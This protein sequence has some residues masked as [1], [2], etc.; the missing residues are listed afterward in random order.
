MAT[1]Y[2]DRTRTVDVRDNRGA[3]ASTAAPVV[4]IGSLVLIVSV[5]LD[6]ASAL[7]D[8]EGAVG[9]GTTT[10]S[11]SGYNVVD[12]RIAGAI[13]LALLIAAALMWLNKRYESWF[14]ADLLCAALSAIVVGT[15]VLFLIDV[16]DTGR[17]AELGPYVALAG[18]VIAH[19]AAL[20]AAVRSGSD[21]ATADEEGRGDIGR[22]PAR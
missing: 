22:R 2:E 12:G 13:G 10:A 15:V 4:L 7:L 17:S 14:D 5:F 3:R 1:K 19:I 20:V 21:R 9:T 18:A 6:W 8:G 16:G 11:L